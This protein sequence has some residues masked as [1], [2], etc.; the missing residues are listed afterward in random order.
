MAMIKCPECGQEISD[1]AKKCV[2]CGKVLIEDKPVT[3]ICSDCGKEN[4]IDATECIHCGCPFE[5]DTTPIPTVQMEKSKKDLK[6][7][8][9][10]VIVVIIVIVMGLIIYNV[11]VVKPKN[12]YNEAMELLEKGK[13]EEAND[14]LE[15]IK[16]YK[17][18]ATIQEQLKYE[19]Y[20][21]STINDL[22]K[23]LKNPDSFQPY[24][25]KFYAS[26]GNNSE[27]ADSQEKETEDLEGKEN[28]YPAC[29][30]HY[31]AQNGFGG[32]TTG[33]VLGYYSNDE[34]T[35]EILGTCDS[36]DED[37]Y[38]LDDEDDVYDLIICRLINLYVDGGNEIGDIDLL[39]LK[40]VL[41]NDAYSTIKIIE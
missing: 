16:N 1:K 34:K 12:T 22:K 36:L 2:H 39:R 21:Y 17:D 19:S 14:I 15:S 6:K 11:K 26:T 13:Y 28:Q 25:V 4:P 29:V 40:T 10:P 33:Y 18:V 7:I 8:I 32:N 23:Y 31:G 20:A 38:D 37:D 27:N 30:I 41:K 9:I 24:E 5:E 35:Y 3:K